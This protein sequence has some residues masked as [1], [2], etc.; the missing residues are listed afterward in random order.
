VNG[1]MEEKTVQFKQNLSA[2][3]SGYQENNREFK[4]RERGHTLF[5]SSTGFST[6]PSSRALHKA[7]V[8]AQMQHKI[9]IL[10]L[11][12]PQTEEAIHALA[13]ILPL[14]HVIT[15]SEQAFQQNTNLVSTDAALKKIRNRSYATLVL[16]Q[17]NNNYKIFDRLDTIKV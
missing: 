9:I 15:G 7:I 2:L 1:L 14:C 17:A 16:Q 5:I 8:A 13:P 12:I 3:L 6:E 10:E 4:E 11:N